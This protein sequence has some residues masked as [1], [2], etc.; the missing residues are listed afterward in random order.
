MRAKLI[1][2][3]ILLTILFFV[4][5]EL[6]NSTKLYPRS[7][8]IWFCIEDSLAGYKMGGLCDFDAWEEGGCRFVWIE[9]GTDYELVCWSYPPYQPGVYI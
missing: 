2:P 6:L 1:I 7:G 9:C 4:T 8:F 5:S 3:A